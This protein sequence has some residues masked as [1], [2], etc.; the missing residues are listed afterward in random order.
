M[1]PFQKNWTVFQI[2]GICP[3]PFDASGSFKIIAA[4]FT[5]FNISAELLSV[6]SSLV[7]GIRNL[8]V[9]LEASVHAL[10]HQAA[11]AVT[12]L[13]MILIAYLKRD[14]IIRLFEK[15]QQLCEANET[16]T[17]LPIFVDAK[18]KTEIITNFLVKHLI[19]GYFIFST[20]LGLSNGIYC[21]IADGRQIIAE[22]L[23]IPYKF[24]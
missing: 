10:C 7:F 15:T 23:L 24:S 14:K 11:A 2:I 18:H 12:V 4:I 6:T 9:D 20:I 19:I 8:G 21:Y 1:K 5:V 16:S 17:N 3:V 22:H 13:Y